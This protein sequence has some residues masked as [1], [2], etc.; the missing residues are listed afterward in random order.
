MQKIYLKVV[1]PV[2]SVTSWL[3]DAAGCEARGPAAPPGKPHA[4]AVLRLHALT[5][6]L[7]CSLSAAEAASSMVLS[8]MEPC[9]PEAAA[10]GPAP[11]VISYPKL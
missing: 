10:Y 4:T 5:A 11:P 2:K 7:R 1:E 8:S 3:S 6:L 9:R